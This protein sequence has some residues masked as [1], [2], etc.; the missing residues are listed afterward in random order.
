M[1]EKN[2]F[3]DQRRGQLAT[4]LTF[5]NVHTHTHGDRCGEKR[6]REKERKTHKEKR[7]GDELTNRLDNNLA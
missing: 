6:E 3:Q 2:C 4:V 1:G 7:N 5:L